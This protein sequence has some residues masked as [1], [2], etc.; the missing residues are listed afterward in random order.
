M[1]GHMARCK[2]IG[3]VAAK[4]SQVLEHPSATTW[5]PLPL[6]P[7]TRP[8][9]EASG[10]LGRPSDGGLERPPGGVQYIQIEAAM[11]EALVIEINDGRRERAEITTKLETIGAAVT[12]H[13]AHERR[14]YDLAQAP[15]P[16]P[17]MDTMEPSSLPTILILGGIIAIIG[18]V[19]VSTEAAHEPAPA[20]PEMG[21]AEVAEPPPARSSSGGAALGDIFD[22][23]GKAARA[24]KSVKG[25]F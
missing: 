10:G 1:F 12:N 2:G 6:R 11:W 17:P 25:L 20:R 4:I 19:L 22:F 16:A 24:V 18:V 3:Q 14:A 21:R 13:W 5:T 8:P 23:V 15:V 9:D 7:P